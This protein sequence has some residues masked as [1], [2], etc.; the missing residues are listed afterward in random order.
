MSDKTQSIREKNSRDIERLFGEHKM[1]SNQ[2]FTFSNVQDEDNIITTTNNIKS[3]KKNPV[4][5]VGNNEVVYLKDW[6]I[7]PVMNWEKGIDAWAVKLNR[8]Y[9]KVYT[10]GE[11]FEDFYFKET[12]TFDSL[13]EVAKEQQEKGNAFRV[14]SWTYKI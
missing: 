10:F 11:E 2:Y 7:L 9:F 6:N 13:V 8:K 4:L 1:S 14:K 3:I 5:I 12:E